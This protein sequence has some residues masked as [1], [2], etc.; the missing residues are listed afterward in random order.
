MADTLPG[1]FTGMLQLFEPLLRFRLS[2][3]GSLNILLVLIWYLLILTP[4]LVTRLESVG[5]QFIDISMPLVQPS[6]HFLNKLIVFSHGDLSPS[7]M[8]YPVSVMTNLQ[9]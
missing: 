8:E 1:R 7:M 9:C 2:L 4:R 3:F 6:F 5:G